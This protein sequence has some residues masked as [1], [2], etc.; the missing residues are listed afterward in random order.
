MAYINGNEILFSAQVK[1]VTTI[2]KQTNPIRTTVTLLASAW[3]EEEENLYSQVVNIA[4]VSAYSMVDLQPSA[5]QGVIFHDKDL[6]LVAENEDGVVTVYAI[7]DKPSKDYTM[8][9]T[10]TELSD[11]RTDGGGDDT[12]TEDNDKILCVVNG[13]WTAVTIADSPV[14]TYIDDYINEALGGDY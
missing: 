1:T 8:Q 12:T 6:A 14:K 4:G 2:S 7:G 9:A 10:I 11:L 13:E 5:E 3:V